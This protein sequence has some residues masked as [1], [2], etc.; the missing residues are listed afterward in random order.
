M[1]VASCK[2]PATDCPVRRAGS[3][4]VRFPLRC[5]VPRLPVA[6]LRRGT[7]V[8]ASSAAQPWQQCQA[9]GKGGEED[10]GSVGQPSQK[11]KNEHCSK[12]TTLFSL[13]VFLF[14]SRFSV[15]AFDLAASFRF[16][17]LCKRCQRTIADTPPPP[18]A[19]AP[20]LWGFVCR[21]RLGA[22]SGFYLFIYIPIVQLQLQLH[23]P[24]CTCLLQGRRRRGA[25]ATTA[26]LMFDWA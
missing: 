24:R 20:P 5:L 2:L 26:S 18:L 17:L 12:L 3:Q 6:I 11:K 23:S 13:Q 16:R 25:G 15:S 7:S 10:G 9:A 14:S 4:S 8:S 21:V 22:K 1:Q 19:T